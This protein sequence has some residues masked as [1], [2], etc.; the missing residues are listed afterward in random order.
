MGPPIVHFVYQEPFRHNPPRILKQSVPIALVELIAPVWEG[1]FAFLV[2]QE[3]FL[4]VQEPHWQIHANH[5]S[6]V[7]TKRIQGQLFVITAVW[8]FLLLLLA[9][10]V[11]LFASFVDPDILAAVEDLLLVLGALQALMLLITEP[12]TGVVIVG[13]VGLGLIVKRLQ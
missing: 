8:V 11:P 2:E 10:L 6:Q 4:Q 1:L 9:A 12:L 13:L 5:A 7:L 3:H